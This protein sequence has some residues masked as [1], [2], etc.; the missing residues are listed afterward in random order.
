VEK[1]TIG[2]EN[3]STQKATPQESYKIWIRMQ[4]GIWILVPY[5]TLS[6]ISIVSI[7]NIN[8]GLVK[9]ESIGGHS[10]MVE[11]KGNVILLH[12]KV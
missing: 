3:A 7:Y 2:K 1:M 12:Y 10:H 11:G 6:D 9:I 4:V 5:D 8:F